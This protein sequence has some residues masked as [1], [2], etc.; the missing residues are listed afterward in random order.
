MSAPQTN[1]SEL[2]ATLKEAARELG[3][4]LTGVCPAVTPEGVHRLGEWLS[5]G[6]AGEMTY[7]SSRHEAYADPNR[8]LDGATS[9]LMLATRYRTENPVAPGPGQARVSR[10][11]WGDDYHDLIHDRLH[12]LADTLRQLVPGAKARGVVDTAPLLEREFA[13]LAGLGWVGKNTLLLNRQEGSWFFLSALLTD[14][15][16][17]YD[18]P[19][20]TDHCGTCTACLDACPTGAFVQPYVLD[21]R[22]CISYLTIELRSPVPLD[23]RAGQGDWLLGCDVCQEVCPWNHRAPESAAAELRP[24]SEMNPIELTELFWLDDD[25]FRQRFR[26]TPLWRPRRRGILRNAAIV[27]GNQRCE[28]S[29]LALV[30]GLQDSEA[31]IRGACA[32]ALGQ[33]ATTHARRALAEQLTHEADLQV[34]EEI[35]AA[36][37]A[38]ALSAELQSSPL[39]PNSSSNDG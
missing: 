3:F 21:A 2:T 7:L 14:V 13:Q 36:Q 30:H 12:R 28:E 26:D 8:V 27:L 1:P 15:V 23:L 9:I 19:H 29:L 20:Q 11:A 39:A 17:A 22:R 16:L 4:S 37:A 31:L 35:V 24:R 38:S 25:A 32:W 5:A 33:I 6:Y 34:R 18:E 10:Y